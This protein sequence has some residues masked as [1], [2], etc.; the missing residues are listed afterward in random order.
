MYDHKINQTRQQILDAFV[1]LVKEKDVSKITIN[2]IT[3]IAK[4]NRGTFYRHF[5]DKFDLIENTETTIFNA[6][7]KSLQDNILNGQIKSI[8]QAKFG[9]YRLELLG[10]LKDN[11]DFISAMLS[12]NGDLTFESKLIAQMRDFS[13]IGLSALGIDFDSMP[14]SR[15]LTMQ[16]M[17][18]GLIGVVRHW[19]ANDDISIETV[20]QTMDTIMSNGIIASFGFEANL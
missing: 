5:D 14:A 6:V 8:T 20:A 10:I 17:A 15:E 16:F 4:I 9:N 3:T 7:E 11:A 1:T 13:M 18:N 12:K 19:L 2:D